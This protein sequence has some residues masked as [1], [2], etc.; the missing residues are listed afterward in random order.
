MHANPI[1]VA[2]IT[3]QWP[4]FPPKPNASGA[5][6]YPINASGKEADCFVTCAI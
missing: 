4:Y 3:G 1:P 2:M 5:R 6:A